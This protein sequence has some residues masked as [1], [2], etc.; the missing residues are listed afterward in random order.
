MDIIGGEKHKSFLTSPYAMTANKLE[1]EEAD[2]QHF[3][4]SFLVSRF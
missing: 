4:V 3:I 1:T 2:R